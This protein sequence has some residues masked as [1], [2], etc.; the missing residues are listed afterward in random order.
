[1]FKRWAKGEYEI[2]ITLRIQEVGDRRPFKA[3]E[4]G[5]EL[6][7]LEKFLKEAREVSPSNPKRMTFKAKGLRMN[8]RITGIEVLRRGEKSIDL[9]LIAEKE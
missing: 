9:K 4:W 8:L 5:N 3:V 1:M 2:E 6:V 7:P